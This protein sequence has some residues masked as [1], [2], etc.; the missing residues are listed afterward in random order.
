[1]TA[2]R[3]VDCVRLP[4][5]DLD[6]GLAF[7]CDRLGHELLW[8]SD[9]AAAVRL[10][11]DDAEL[12]LQVERPE[13]E[14]DLLVGSVDEAVAEVVAAGGSVVDPASDIPVGRVARVADPF[15]NVLTVLDLSRGRYGTDGDGQ[16][17]GV[18]PA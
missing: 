16:V 6:A 9:T 8:R 3:A 5:P 13:P 10:P 4:V 11:D 2:L 14:V 12:V 15:G 17:L 7:Y 18:R 1:M